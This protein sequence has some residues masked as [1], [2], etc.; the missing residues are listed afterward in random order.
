M[1]EAV[2][3][4]FDENQAEVKSEGF[5]RAGSEQDAVKGE[6]PS[7]YDVELDSI[8]PVWNRLFQENKSLEYFER[9]RKEDPV[10]F[11]DTEIAGR[12]WSLTRYDDIKAVDMDHKNFSSAHGITLGFPIDRPLPEGALDISLFIAMDPPKHDVHT[13]TLPPVVSPIKIAGIQPK[14]RERTPK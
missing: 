1:S 8:N 6:I 3:V 12:Y 4:E 9:L 14:N 2:D 7:A 10:H 5:A 13:K 11:N